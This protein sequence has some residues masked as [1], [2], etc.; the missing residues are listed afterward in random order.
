MVAQRYGEELGYLH[1]NIIKTILTIFCCLSIFLDSS[2]TVRFS[3]SWL[4][5]HKTRQGIFDAVLKG[6]IDFQSVLK[7]SNSEKYLIGKMLSQCPS[8]PLPVGAAFHAA[9]AIE[10][11]N[12]NAAGPSA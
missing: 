7:I 4:G 8:E 5:V 9:V 1:A 11:L 2:C 10:Y 6:L 3:L 12:K